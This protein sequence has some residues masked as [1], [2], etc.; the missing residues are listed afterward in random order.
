MDKQL[1]LVTGGTG[2]VGSHLKNYLL[3]STCLCPTRATVDIRDKEKLKEFVKSVNPT[4]VIHL[5]AQ[6][7]VPRSFEDPYETFDINFIGTLNLLMALKAADFKGKM[8]YVSSGEVYGILPEK[9]LPVVEDYPLKPVNPYAVSK[10]AAEA[11]CYQWSQTSNFQ[12]IIVRPFNHIGPGQSEY[13]AIPD[14]AKQIIEIKLGLR[15]N[16]INVGALDV[17]RDFTDVRDI[18][19]AYILLLNKGINGQV[20][21]VCSGK[22]VEMRFVLQTMIEFASINAEIIEDKSRFRKSSHRRIC[23]SFQKLKCDTGWVPKIPIIQTLKDV[24]SDTER[25]FER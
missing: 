22:E 20:Y 16:V 21:N 8:I 12:I 14:F 23:G 18:V 15:K 6:T 10:I 11:L 24:L 17:T 25:K 4:S 3:P 19:Q 5:A 2:F 13:F 9:A 7:T 1:T